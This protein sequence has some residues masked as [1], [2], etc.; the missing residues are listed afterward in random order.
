MEDE[1][2]QQAVL[3][4]AA[5][6]GRATDTTLAH[7]TLGEVVI[8]REIM[9]DPEVAGVIAQIFEVY[10]VNLAE[11]T[12]GDPANK[13][14]PETGYPEFFFKKIFKAIKKVLK[15][16]IGKIALPAALSFFAPGIGTA[17]GAGLG[18][19]T[20]AAPIVGGGLIG[21]A[22]G[23]I[24]GGG[25]KGALLGGLS[26]G[27]GGALNSGGASGL[28]GKATGTFGPATPAQV[29]SAGST[30]AAL[31]KLASGTGIRGA[32]SSFGSGASTG[33]VG[34]LSSFVKPATSLFGGMQEQDTI[35]EAKKAM[36][37]AQ[38]KAASAVNPYAE[39]GL[40]A[41][42]QLTNNLAAGFNPGD[43]ASE[44]G[45]QF[46]LNQGLDA[47]NKSLAAQGM[48]QSGAA[49]KA[50]QEYGQGFA[51]QEYGNAYDR[52][53]QQNQQLAGVGGTGYNAA[54]A[55]GNIYG[56]QGQ[57]QS[58]ALIYSADRKNKTIAE[59]LAGLGYK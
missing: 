52:W 56:N 24:S 48:G 34:N 50:A 20:A 32:L 46:R 4:E 49:L 40:Q 26:G 39:Q 9:E 3:Q 45:Y 7:L 12:V 59:I 2:M 29:A 55:V 41:Q 25:I 53:L 28:L 33:G 6:A 37:A 23:A 31:S 36:L 30:N 54:N 11:F 51:Q 27:V 14:N 17:L 13:I 16:P 44:K 38:G 57:I 10:G 47:Q 8:P 15:S 18:A 58:D 19:G 5:D 21:A 22:T 1:M 43:L 35:D 42:T